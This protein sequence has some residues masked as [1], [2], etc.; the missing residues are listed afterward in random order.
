MAELTAV[1]WS[2]A[3]HDVNMI[4]A[5]AAITEIEN[6]D[7]NLVTGDLIGANHSQENQAGE[8]LETMIAKGLE[9]ARNSPNLQKVQE[10]MEKYQ[11]QSS[12]DLEKMPADEREEFAIAYQAHQEDMQRAILGSVV[13]SYEQLKPALQKLASKSKIVGILGNHDLTPAYKL[14]GDLIDFAEL[15]EEVTVVGK[16]GTKFSIKGTNNTFEI[17]RT[18]AS[19]QAMQQML[20]PYFINYAEGHHAGDDEKLK[21]VQQA[22]RDRLNGG[23][24]IFL[25]HVQ[26]ESYMGAHGE[27]TEEAVAASKSTY[28]GHSHSGEVTIHNGKPV[29]RT[30]MNHIFVYD[31]NAKKEVEAVRIYKIN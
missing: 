15:Q 29:F 25:T 24:D 22:T 30:G 4:L 9:S 14:L 26:P 3:H 2:D 21:K 19:D 7:V 6:A 1:H 16:N 27:A 5:A 28:C 8:T 13:E 18:Y 17:P 31:Y 23:A 11:I 10:T 20:M 12:E